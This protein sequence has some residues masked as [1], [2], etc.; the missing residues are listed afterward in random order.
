MCLT[1]EAV[2]FYNGEPDPTPNPVLNGPGIFDQAADEAE[3]EEAERVAQTA[4][5]ILGGGYTVIRVTRLI[6]ISGII[7]LR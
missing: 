2:S 4:L 7:I 3:R 5:Q 1:T 6:P